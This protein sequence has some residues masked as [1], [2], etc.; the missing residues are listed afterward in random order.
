MKITNRQLRS[1]IEEEKTKLLRENIEKP[2][3][4][5]ALILANAIESG[6]FDGLEE[7]GAD[8]NEADQLINQLYNR[9]D[10]VKE[11]LFSGLEDYKRKLGL[12]GM[13]KPRNEGTDLDE[14]SDAWRQILGNCTGKPKPKNEGADLDDM[15]DSWR[16]IL[17]NCLTNKGKK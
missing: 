17:G 4:A 6:V 3:N 5:D 11:S 8:A 16:Q 1:I 13:P 10:I 14:M 9:M 2:V 15:S 7:L 12:T